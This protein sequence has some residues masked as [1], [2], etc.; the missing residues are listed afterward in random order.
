MQA[1]VAVVALVSVVAAAVVSQLPTPATLPPQ[2]TCLSC[3]FYIKFTAHNPPHEY[4]SFCWLL[5]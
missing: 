3:T 5:A 2:W 4:K 1:V